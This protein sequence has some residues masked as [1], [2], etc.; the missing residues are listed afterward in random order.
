MSAEGGKKERI[1]I[2]RQQLIAGDGIRNLLGHA[3]NFSDKNSTFASITIKIGGTEKTR[4]Q[5]WGKLTP[6][7]E[8]TERSTEGK[9]FLGI[10]N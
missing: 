8:G 4:N 2:R 9:T 10:R 1:P 5:K 7:N 3:R 6:D